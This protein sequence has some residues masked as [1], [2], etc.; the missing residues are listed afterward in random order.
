MQ[1]WDIADADRKQPKWQA[2]NLPNDELDLA[3]PIFD[4]DVCYL[5]NTSVCT[6]TGYGDVREYDIR[7]PRR[8]VINAKLT[9]GD[10]MLSKIQRSLTNEHLIYTSNQE[11]HIIMAD[12]RNSK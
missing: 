2:R 4:T 7:G 3:I 6:C 8:P 9:E 5:T 11:G 10:I 12:R 1:V